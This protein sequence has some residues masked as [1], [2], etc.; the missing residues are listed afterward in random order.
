MEVVKLVGLVENDVA[1]LELELLVV[2][3]YNDFALIDVHKLPKVVAFS[4]VAVV[5]FVLEIV[6]CEDLVD[7]K[8]PF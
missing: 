7:D 1:L 4:Y 8:G 3:I 2:H 5:L 6:D